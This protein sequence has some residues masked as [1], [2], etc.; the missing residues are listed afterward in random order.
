[1]RRD[2][3]SHAAILSPITKPNNVKLSHDPT[4]PLPRRPDHMGGQRR[5][6]ELMEAAQ[7]N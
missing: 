2:V 7:V 5:Y 3:F 6:D 1:M 4:S